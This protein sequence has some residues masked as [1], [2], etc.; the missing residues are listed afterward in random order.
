MAR[1]CWKC[2]RRMPSTRSE[3]HPHWPWS[4]VGGPISNSS[5]CHEIVLLIFSPF[6]LCH[7]FFLFAQQCSRIESI[8]AAETKMNYVPDWMD[9]R[10]PGRKKS[11]IFTNMKD[12]NVVDWKINIRE[13]EASR[14]K[15]KRQFIFL[16]FIFL[17]FSFCSADAHAC[18]YEMSFRTS[19]KCKWKFISQKR[20]AKV[21]P[22]EID[23]FM[24]INYW[25]VCARRERRKGAEE[26]KSI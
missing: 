18:T 16:N 5:G 19:G 11:E 25:R 2:H 14:R 9:L 26:K 23:I 15:K 24:T 22:D 6:S 3:T 8:A 1:I 12:I 4:E 13:F 17:P 7:H 21:C 20:T 10:R